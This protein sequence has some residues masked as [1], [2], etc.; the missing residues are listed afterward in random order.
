MKKVF[1][2]LAFVLAFVCDLSAQ[3]VSIN[4]KS[5]KIVTEKVVILNGTTYQDAVKPKSFEAIISKMQSTGNS[6]SVNGGLAPV[7]AATNGKLYAIVKT[8]QG[9]VKIALNAKKE[10]S[11]E[12]SN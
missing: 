4:G 1:F 8:P 11:N 7:Y 10:S 12:S 3:T 2:I 6:Y 5:R 9:V